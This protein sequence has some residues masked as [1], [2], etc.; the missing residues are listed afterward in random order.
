MTQNEFRFLQSRSAKEAMYKRLIYALGYFAILLGVIVNSVSCRECLA[1][2]TVRSVCGNYVYP[3]ALISL[4]H[5]MVIMYDYSCCFNYVIKIITDPIL[6]L[7]SSWQ[8]S[9]KSLEVSY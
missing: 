3:V 7:H 6:K 9:L 1:K 4:L 5:L 2:Y 8:L